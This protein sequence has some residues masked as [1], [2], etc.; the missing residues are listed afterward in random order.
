[1]RLDDLAEIGRLFLR[2]EIRIGWE[3]GVQFV[4]LLDQL[5]YRS[6]IGDFLSA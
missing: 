6:L 1:M 3:R 4:A 2:G 5:R